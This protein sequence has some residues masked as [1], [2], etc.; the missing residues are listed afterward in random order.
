[1]YSNKNNVLNNTVSKS[2]YGLQLDCSNSNIITYNN[3][4][5]NNYGIHLY[6]S[7]DNNIYLNNFKT[8]FPS[9][10]QDYFSYASN[11]SWN[12]PQLIR[13][14][15]N[16]TIQKSYV[17]NYWS[18]YEGNDSNANGIGDTT[19]NIRASGELPCEHA[20]IPYEYVNKDY[21]PLMVKFEVLD[22]MGMEIDK[23]PPITNALVGSPQYIQGKN[24]FIGVTT[25]ISIES[26]DEWVD[27]II[28]KIDDEPW[29][30]YTS[31]F[32]L[33]G[34]AEGEHTL[35]YYGIDKTGNVETVKNT[36][37][38]IDTSA[39]TTTASLE[40]GTY[41]GTITVTLTSTDNGSGV[42]VTYYQI[43]DTE[44]P[45]K[46]QEPVKITQP[47]EYT[48]N[49]YSIDNLGNTE[50]KKSVTYVIREIPFF[51]TPF[52]IAVIS[53]AVITILLISIIILRK[54]KI[55]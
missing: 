25:N 54:R 55:S 28:F 21:F 4:I 45:T 11:N 19:F 43:S 15:Y 46:Y 30:N 8:T 38:I 9:T 14:K 53:I 29:K 27:R 42:N 44:T 7:Y 12:S 51:E 26:F 13:Y 34:Y 39:P 23:N 10:T 20:Y 50:T 24:A 33:T 5:D 6:S 3:F 52:G 37:I 48:I 22:I 1:L 41:S 2:A 35:F 47:G 31:S 36:S 40:A 17:G 18:D 16:G 49:Y 32:N